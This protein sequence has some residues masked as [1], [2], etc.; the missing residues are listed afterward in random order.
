MSDAG[1]TRAALLVAALVFSTVLGP[2][3]ALPLMGMVGLLIVEQV[4]FGGRLS[5]LLGGLLDWASPA[6]RQRVIRHEAGHV[7]VAYLL[8]IPLLGYVLNPWQA[9]RRGI[10]GYG[11]V[12]LD[13]APMR[14]WQAQGGIPWADVERYGT[15]WMAG[16][17]AES[18]Y[19][20]QATGDEQDRRQLSLL[21]SGIPSMQP[22]TT[23]AKV[24]GQI[25]RFLRQ[26]QALLQAHPEAYAVTV[27][28]LEQ[29]SPW[30]DCLAAIAASLE[31]E[32]PQEV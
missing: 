32:P 28:H 21:L 27:Q 2:R 9:F 10:P 3:V 18:L 15:F 14:N 22:L 25:N 5:G 20:G 29:G 4:V 26:S 24:K 17:A 19:Y 16:A 11:G 8:R 13:Q 6:Y 12:E 7:L 23:P 1:V 31:Q 30:E